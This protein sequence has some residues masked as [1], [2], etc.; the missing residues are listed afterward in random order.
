MSRS[1]E[2]NYAINLP[3]GALEVHLEPSKAHSF[4]IK[5]ETSST[6][7][8]AYYETLREA[9]LDAKEKLG[10]ELT[11]LRDAAG[12]FENSKEAK[13]RTGDVEEEEREEGEEDA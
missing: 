2:A 6:G 13:S 9:V 11:V 3:T 12:G 5:A 4:P 1:I 8:A 7:Q 10:E